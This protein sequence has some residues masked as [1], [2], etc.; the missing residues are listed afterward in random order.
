MIR[1]VPLGKESEIK[2]CA[3]WFWFESHRHFIYEMHFREVSRVFT[4]SICVVVSGPNLALFLP[5]IV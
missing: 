4:Y 1:R 3:Q 5:I 2:H